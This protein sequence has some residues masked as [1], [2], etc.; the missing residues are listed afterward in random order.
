LAH[1]SRAARSRAISMKK[2]E[3]IDR[4]KRMRGAMSSMLKPRACMA[5]T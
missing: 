1:S 4:E 2:L 3:P 5:R